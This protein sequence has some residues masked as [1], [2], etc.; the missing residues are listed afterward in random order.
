[1]NQDIHE[2]LGHTIEGC[3]R[4]SSIAPPTPSARPVEIPIIPNVVL[5]EYWGRRS[6]K[7]LKDYEYGVGIAKYGD[8][9]LTPK[10]FLKRLSFSLAN[11]LTNEYN[12]RN[13]SADELKPALDILDASLKLI[14]GE[15]TKKGMA[16]EQMLSVIAVLSG[17]IHNYERTR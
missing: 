13:T 11:S 2:L 8:N 1:M 15:M 10:N 7:L 9:D 5:Q 3:T 12:K 6:N 17:F 4:E 16:D 14:A